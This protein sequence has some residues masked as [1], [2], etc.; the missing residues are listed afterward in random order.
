MHIIFVESY[1]TYLYLRQFDWTYD[2][3][4]DTFDL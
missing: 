1:I 3:Q 2:V 4:T